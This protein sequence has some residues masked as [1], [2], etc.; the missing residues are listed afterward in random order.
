M[1]KNVL[2]IFVCM[3]LISI[4]IFPS[5]SSKVVENESKNNHSGEY[6]IRFPR[7]NLPIPLGTWLENTY[8]VSSESTNQSYG[9]AM[10]VDQ[11]GNVHITWTENPD[12]VDWNIMYKCLPIEATWDANPWD[13]YPTDLVS[14]ESDPSIVSAEPSIAIGPDGL[15]HIAWKDGTDINSEGD[16]YFDIFY[17][18]K[19]MGG[20]WTDHTTEV[21]SNEPTELRCDDPTLIVDSYGTVHVVWISKNNDDEGELHYNNKTVGGIW[22]NTTV[23]N[24]WP[25]DFEEPVLAIDSQ[26]KL[27]LVYG[28]EYT[29]SSDDKDI[30]YRN[31]TYGK[32]W[33]SSTLVSEG[34][35]E[36][37]ESPTIALSL[38][39]PPTVH[40]AWWEEVL[41]SL[42]EIFYREC[43]PTWDNVEQVTDSAHACV[44]PS[45]QVRPGLF[46]KQF[47]Y[48]AFSENVDPSGGEWHIQVIW[49]YVGETWP[50]T[51]MTISDE[52]TEMADNPVLCREPFYYTYRIHCAWDDTTPYTGSGVDEDIFYKRTSPLVFLKIIPDAWRGCAIAVENPE[53]YLL[54]NIPWWIDVH[55]KWFIFGRIHAE[56][57]IDQI[58][59]GETIVI[60]HTKFFGLGPATIFAQADEAVKFA[61]AFIIGPFVFIQQK[62]Q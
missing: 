54:D 43:E 16:G 2:V 59:P 19:S 6:D 10:A 9:P 23:I 44:N 51:Y 46:N 3:L 15:I 57:I 26:D 61:K 33:S 22:E 38:D 11:D 17:K 62:P 14:T 30:Y 42:K 18:Y 7:G 5:L 28:C 48:I 55:C 25:Y 21:V 40:V 56:G 24:G 34:S 37:S 32:S 1:S 36:D 52:A 4:T 49:K 13:D 50:T 45:I 31:K 58:R 35:D 53:E 39:D 12:A 20:T 41:G 60:K 29:E 27:H 8:L 47:V